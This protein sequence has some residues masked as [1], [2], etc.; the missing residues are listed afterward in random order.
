[1]TRNNGKKDVH[2]TDN[3]SGRELTF[4]IEQLWQV[5]NL[6]MLG[7]TNAQLSLFFQVSEST[8][9][10]WI[11]NNEEFAAARRRG[12]LAADMEVVKGLYKRAV[13]F[14]FQEEKI[15]R[16]GRKLKRKKINTYV[17]PD[18]KAASLWLAARQRLQWTQ[19]QK[20]QHGGVIEHKHTKVEDLP[21]HELK[22]ETQEFLFEITQ[23]QL[24]ALDASRNN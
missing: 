11:R 17:I 6:A 4:T 12:G 1:M 13:G 7:A 24:P 18:T 2:V 16:V 5:E 8:I 22:P 9:E 10:Y 3:K 15:F 20:V 14:V 23:A 21:V 19:T